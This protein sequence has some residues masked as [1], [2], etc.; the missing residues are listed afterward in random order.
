MDNT[1]DGP[2]TWHLN[3]QDDIDELRS[4][5]SFANP[6]LVVT[7]DGAV[8]E[9][10][11]DTEDDTLQLHRLRGQNGCIQIEAESLTHALSLLQGGAVVYTI[12]VDD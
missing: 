10:W 12:E 4:E 9:V 2:F 1:F 5:L 8:W 3:S 7:P 6:K 11:V